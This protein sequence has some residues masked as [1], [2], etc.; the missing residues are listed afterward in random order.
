VIEETGNKTLA[1]AGVKSQG[2]SVGARKTLQT[3][4]KKSGA[5][6]K[7]A[8]AN[9]KV[10][11]TSSKSTKNEKTAGESPKIVGNAPSNSVSVSDIGIPCSI[12][13]ITCRL[14]H[15]YKTTWAC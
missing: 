5:E 10:S 15:F 1:K 6:E 4:S 12:P 11:K 14:D 2:K 8:H 7:T 13:L 9:T 3:K